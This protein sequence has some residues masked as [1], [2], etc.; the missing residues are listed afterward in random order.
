MTAVLK[1][2]KI[3]TS[4]MGN[5]KNGGCPR[6]DKLRLIADE[7][8]CTMS[9]LRWGDE[10]ISPGEI[11]KAP[12]PE[13]QG[14]EIEDMCNLLFLL[15]SRSVRA[16]VSRIARIPVQTLDA[17]VNGEKDLDD[18]I[19]VRIG[20]FFGSSVPTLLSNDR[21]LLLVPAPRYKEQKAPAP[22]G[23]RA[24]QSPEKIRLDELTADF[25]EEEI[26]QMVGVALHVKAMRTS[27]EE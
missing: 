27:P 15:Q 2:L 21:S 20:R 4:N 24:G 6:E 17:I 3:P 5:W 11:K 8:S 19:L 23:A 18:D 9:F 10:D 25:S 26:N 13:G 14:D 16:T 22:E 12:H 7:L 1:K